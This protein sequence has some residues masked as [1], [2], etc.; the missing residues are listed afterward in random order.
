MEALEFNSSHG[1]EFANYKRALVRLDAIRR[2][3]RFI[4]LPDSVRG[5]Y[6]P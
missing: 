6:L 2:F 4:L 1:Y 5:P 3:S